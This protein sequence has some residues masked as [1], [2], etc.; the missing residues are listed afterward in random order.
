[1]ISSLELARLCGVSQGTVDRALHGRSG[2]SEKTRARILAEAERHGYAPNPAAREIITGRSSVVAA[3]MPQINSVFFMDLFDALKNHLRSNGLRMIFSA[4]ADEAEFIELLEEMSSR[5]PRGLV[6]IPPR[7]DIALPTRISRN[8]NLVSLIS[9]VAGNT[10][11]L[12]SPDE[13]SVGA[14]AA[15][16]LLGLGRKRLMHL[17]YPRNSRAIIARNEGFE[18]VCAGKG[19]EFTTSHRVDPK[20]MAAELAEFNPDGVFCHNDW[21]A[22]SALRH[23]EK[24][25]IAVPEDVSI[26]GVDDSPTFNRLNDE[27]TTIPYPYEWC[28]ERVSAILADTQSASPPP[29][30][31]PAVVVKRT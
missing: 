8:T 11:Q 14:V 27:I 29:P 25:G 28:A 24:R 20:D 6:F 9:P 13:H 18:S 21:L 5:R 4:Y 7:D 23:F 30:P 3:L 22:L 15:G 31:P 2:I 17:T 16:H 1:M 19:V 26:I 10:V 12:V